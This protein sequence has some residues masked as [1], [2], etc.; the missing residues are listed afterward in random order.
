MENPKPEK[1][2][3]VE[4]VREKLSASNAAL[5]TEYRGLTVRD[6]AFLTGGRNPVDAVVAIGC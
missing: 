6:L 5:F 3:V 1:V 4:E 2:A